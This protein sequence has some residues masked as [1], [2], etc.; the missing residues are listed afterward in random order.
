MH[1]LVT[2]ASGFVGRR[3]VAALRDTDHAVTVL[4]R[5]A[6]TYD[7]AP[8]V[9]VVEGDVLEP[10]SFEPSL[11]GVD[12]AYY[13]IHAMDADGDFVERDRRAARNFERAANAADVDRIV[14]LSGLGDDGDDLSPHLASRRAVEST[15]AEG[16]ADVTV[17]RAAIIV[18]AESAS[19]R[20]IFQLATRLPVMVTPQW[21]HVACQPIAID[22][23]IAYLLAVLDLPETAG[24]VYEIGGP[25]VLTYRD[26]LTET[27]AV[28]TGREP[29]IVPVPVLSPRLSAYWVDLVTDVPAGLAH[30]LIEGVRNPVVVTDDRL[31]R[32]VDIELTPFETAVRDAIEAETGDGGVVRKR[33]ATRGTE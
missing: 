29:I 5:D 14:Y 31:Q 26:L 30:P 2:G 25:D 24:E 22:D 17:L 27:A 15:L 33:A 19:F 1:V 9:T 6:S 8:D 21:V 4:V 18:G 16:T 32:L 7:P 11:D 3:L 20:M 28:A 12:V 13:L 10:G 23:V